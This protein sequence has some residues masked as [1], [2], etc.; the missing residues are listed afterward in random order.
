MFK[1]QM[2]SIHPE[3]VLSLS[4]SLFIKFSLNVKSIMVAKS[5]FLSLVLR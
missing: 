1:I 5:T 2:L 3:L 4:C